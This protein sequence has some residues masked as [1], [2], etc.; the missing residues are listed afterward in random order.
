VHT[1]AAFVTNGQPAKAMQPGQR[2]LDD[3]AGAAQA[4]A[5]RRAPLGELGRD[6]SAVQL[7]AMPLRVVAAIALNQAGLP[8]GMTDAASHERHGVDEWQQLRDVVSVGGRQDRDE[9]NPLRVGE[10]MMLRPGFAAIGRVR[11]SF[12]PPRGARREELSTTAR[13]K[14]S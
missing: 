2:A 3:P 5:V 13:A 1:R 6:P 11:S 12:F 7:I 14:S 9:R 4:A 10:N 8:N